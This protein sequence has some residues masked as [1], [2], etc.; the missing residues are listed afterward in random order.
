MLSFLGVSWSFLE[1]LHEQY[2]CSFLCCT[3]AIDQYLVTNRKA[4][5]LHEQNIDN[6]G[7]APHT[8]LTE[9]G[10]QKLFSRCMVSI[11]STALYIS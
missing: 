8:M 9:L 3:T 2:F 1:L 11:K 4:L 6:G 7:A 5:I 10:D